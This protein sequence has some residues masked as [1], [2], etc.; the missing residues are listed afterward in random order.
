[1][2]RIR[3]KE[4][5]ITDEA[6]DKMRAAKVGKKPSPETCEE[7]RLVRMG[8]RNPMFGVHRFGDKNPMFGKHHSQERKL[9]IILAM[10]NV[11]AD[12]FNHLVERIKIFLLH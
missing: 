9:R 1:M 8:D 4:S 6:R 2:P 11:I 12:E 5:I 10:S 3:E 7:I